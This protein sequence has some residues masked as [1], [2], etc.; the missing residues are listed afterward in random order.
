MSIIDNARAH[1]KGIE[2]GSLEVDE[3]SDADGNPATIY[4][5][6][7]TVAEKNRLY[8]MSKKDDLELLVRTLIMKAEDEAGEKIFTIEDK[9][10]LLTE[11]DAE[12]IAHIVTEMHGGASAEDMEL[13]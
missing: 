8:K 2:R 4:W 9:R 13:D 6:P 7:F 10:T 5:T 3:W 12:V 11:A 1:F